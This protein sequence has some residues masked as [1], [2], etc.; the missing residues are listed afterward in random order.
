MYNQDETLGSNIFDGLRK[1]GKGDPS[2]ASSPFLRISCRIY[3]H[4][5]SPKPPSD[6]DDD[7]ELRSQKASRKRLRRHQDF[8]LE[9]GGKS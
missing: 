2:A 4:R 1:L 9:D 7:G 5:I 3:T 8:S 6:L